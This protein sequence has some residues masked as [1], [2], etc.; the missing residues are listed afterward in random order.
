MGRRRTLAL[1]IIIIICF[2]TASAMAAERVLTFDDP[3]GG[4]CYNSWFESGCRV[5]LVNTTAAD[6]MTPSSSAS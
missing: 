1:A 2:G 5:E 3:G 4:A 6:C